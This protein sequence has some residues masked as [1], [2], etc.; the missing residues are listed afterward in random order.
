MTK[1]TRNITNG[2]GSITLDN[3]NVGTYNVTVRTRET[4]TLEEGTATGTITIFNQKPVPD[5]ISVHGPILNDDGDTVFSLM[6]RKG[7]TILTP[8]PNSLVL[9]DT[10]QYTTGCSVTLAYSNNDRKQPVLQ[11]VVSGDHRNILIDATY[12]EDAH[13]DDTSFNI[14]LGSGTVT[15]S[16]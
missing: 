4:S 9:V 7:T 15:I 14:D 8:S 6:F 13:I 3:L 1:Y 2:T 12:N 16:T 10:D 5:N 11:V